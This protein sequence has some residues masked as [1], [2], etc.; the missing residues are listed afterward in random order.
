MPIINYD[1]KVNELKMEDIVYHGSKVDNYNY[2]EINWQ[3]LYGCNYKCS[4]CFG[5][6]ILKNDF[7]SIEKLKKAVDKI[8][9]IKKEY[10]SFTL[11]G[12]EVTYHPD[13]LELVKYIYSFD[14]KISILLISNA[15][16]SIDYFDKLLS[17]VGNNEFSMNFSVHFE[18][19]DLNHIKE[20]IKLFNKYKYTI[21][22][23]FMLHPDYKEKIYNF[24]D[25]LIE[26]KKEYFF[27]FGITELREPPDFS[28]I[29]SRYDKDFFTWIDSARK[30]IYNVKSNAVP[31]QKRHMLFPCSYFTKK[32]NDLTENISINH[33]L[34]LRNNLKQFQG[35]Y[36]CG[37][38]NLLRIE[39]NGSYKGAVCRQF[40]IVG[41][42]YEDEDIDL[43]KLSEYVKC[44]ILQCGCSSNDRC[45]KYKNEKEAKKY[46]LNYRK[47]YPEL[48]ME[49]LLNTIEELKKDI[50]SNNKNNV[51]DVNKNLTNINNRVNDVNKNL[52]NVN[53]KVN[54]IDNKFNNKID[55]LIDTLAW[56][57]PFKKKR[58]EF[59]NKFK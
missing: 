57:I 28:R 40:P 17:Y 1:D 24:F 23:N 44:N 29:D 53:N 22:V 45:N 13:F 3:I 58:D 20:L 47:K 56:W 12:G 31:F 59:R 21:N 36:C 46:V 52:T 18:Y 50:N 6:D 10:Y 42:I 30:T 55:K 41:N 39:S 54:S 51:D 14:A 37:G 26:M 33:N 32:T 9:R 48:M 34:A 27:N 19:A 4:Y 2:L 11:L 8:F 49:Y 38:E 43:Y 35:F 7:T 16:K 25:E 15:S 5:Q